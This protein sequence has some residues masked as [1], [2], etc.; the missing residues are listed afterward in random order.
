MSAAS[1]ESDEAEECDDPDLEIKPDYE[2]YLNNHRVKEILNKKNI[3]TEK[4]QA[5][6]FLDV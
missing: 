4:E 6:F 3:E 5:K 1:L 2:E